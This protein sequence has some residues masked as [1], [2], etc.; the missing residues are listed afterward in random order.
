MEGP[1]DVQM[2]V[3]LECT[4][5]RLHFVW[6]RRR[7]CL[8]QLQLLRYR[9]V[10]SKKLFIGCSYDK[11]VKKSKNIA[12]TLSSKSDS[13]IS[14]DFLSSNSTFL[15]TSFGFS[16]FFTFF[17]CMITSNLAEHFSSSSV[18]QVKTA[19]SL[20][21]ASKMTFNDHFFI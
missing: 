6:Y 2:K 4:F 3:V 5:L 15:I 10:L 16:T 17:S 20:H 12:F 8:L 21:C 11:T 18:T 19:S 13:T 9:L 7:Q 14:Y 1:F